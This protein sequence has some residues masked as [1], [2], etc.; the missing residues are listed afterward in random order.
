MSLQF[1]EFRLPDF[2]RDVKALP[3]LHVE[4]LLNSTYCASSSSLR[5]KEHPHTNKLYYYNNYCTIMHTAP[6]PARDVP[7]GNW[8]VMSPNNDINGVITSADLR[9]GVISLTLIMGMT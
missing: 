2:S 1:F 3:R 9:C 4:K 6:P 8:T 5:Q 7:P